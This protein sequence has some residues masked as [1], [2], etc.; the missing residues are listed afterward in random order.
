M[1]TRAL[2]FILISI[3]LSACSTVS[4]KDPSRWPAE[5]A[6]RDY[7]ID[8]FNADSENQQW[9]NQD[10][11]LRWVVRFYR[12]WA[13]YPRGWKWLTK[14][15]SETVEGEQK[16][17]LAQAMASLGERISSE[18][19]KDGRGR[20][21]NTTHLMIWGDALKLAVKEGRQIELASQISVDVDDLIAS[22]I[23]PEV[24]DLD[25]YF[26]PDE[27]HSDIAHEEGADQFDDPFDV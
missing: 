8:V 6:E 27:E 20:T 2:L 12:G 25:R 17:Q 14:E 19:S 10:D 7:Y 21:V 13:L 23:S 1:E 24:I 11:Y 22:R 5:M 18:W 3:L 4:T 15:V 26:G 9:Q 16:V